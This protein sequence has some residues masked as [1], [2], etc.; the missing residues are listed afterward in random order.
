MLFEGNPAH[1]TSLKPEA[2][3]RGDIL[4]EGLLVVR[5]S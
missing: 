4:L 3:A 1:E 5:A 2:A